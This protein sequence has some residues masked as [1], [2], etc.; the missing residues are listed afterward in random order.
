MTLEAGTMRERIKPQY[1]TVTRNTIGEEV[2]TW[3]DLITTTTDNAIWAEVWPLKGREFFAAQQTQYAADV[4]FRIRYRSD[5]TREHRVLWNS[6]PYDIVQIL[7]VGAGG[8]TT[9]ILAINGIRNGK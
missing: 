2:V 3:N 6:E 1:K 7:E 8:E 9:E 5:L 4:R